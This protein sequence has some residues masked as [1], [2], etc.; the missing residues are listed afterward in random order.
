MRLV[1]ILALLALAG[2]G[3]EPPIATKATNNPNVP[4]SLLFEHE[5]CSVYRFR[6]DGRHHYFVTCAGSRLRSA[7]NSYAEQQGKTTINRS[8]SITTID[9]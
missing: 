6:D 3:G 5:G 7:I 2:C 9:P 4:V 1:L 8:K